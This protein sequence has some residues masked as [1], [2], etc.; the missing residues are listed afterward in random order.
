MQSPGE[1]H[2]AAMSHIWSDMST[3]SE[4]GFRSRAHTYLS[5]LIGQSADV[6]SHQQDEHG[7]IKSIG[8]M[9]IIVLIPTVALLGAMAA[10]LKGAIDTTSDVT[11]AW[12]TLD[13]GLSLYRMVRALQEERGISSTYISSDVDDQ[14]LFE[15]LRLAQHGVDDL[16]GRIDPWI[17]VKV[18]ETESAST[19]L[20]FARYLTEHRTRMLIFR[21]EVTFNENILFYTNATSGFLNLI[22][23]YVELPPVRAI[24][25]KFVAF[26]S[27]LRRSDSVGI[28]RA[29]GSVYFTQCHLD[30][31]DRLWFMELQAMADEYRNLMGQYYIDMERH[32]VEMETKDDTLQRAIGT[33]GMEIIDGTRESACANLSS[34]EKVERR[35]HWFENLTNYI[36]I[37]NEIARDVASI[38]HGYLDDMVSQSSQDVVIYSVLIGVVTAIS[39]VVGVWY[40]AHIHKMATEI[41]SFARYITSKVK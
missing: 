26:V 22:E 13:G 19:P 25:S 37:H 40:G 2:A 6:L 35:T 17:E 15:R 21:D 16:I 41:Q 39:G 4:D 30:P 11:L 1:N 27:I 33:L 31:G 36:T 23:N 3:Y 20:D 28:Q 8:R 32:L 34:V 9:V 38:I 24:W 10:G 14:E 5:S 29:I 12:Q 7:R 18:T